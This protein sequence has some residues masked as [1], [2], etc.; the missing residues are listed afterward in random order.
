MSVHDARDAE[1]ETG[2]LKL[3]AAIT[4]LIDEWYGGG[5]WFDDEGGRWAFLG[6]L[7]RALGHLEAAA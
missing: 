7:E 1:L 2:A 3:N 4:I 5:G 6:L